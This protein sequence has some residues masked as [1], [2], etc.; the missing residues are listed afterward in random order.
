DEVIAVDKTAFDSV[1]SIF[2]PRRLGALIALALRLRRSRPGT[3]IVFHHLV[4]RWGALKYAALALV[5]GARRRV[6]LDNG[7]GWFLTDRVPDRGFGAVH[8]SEYWLQ[9]AAAAGA[10]EPTEWRLSVKAKDAEAIQT[11]MR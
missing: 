11:L 6:G 2:D 8:E 3:V 10:K 7:R 5:G 1:R 9:V 4:R